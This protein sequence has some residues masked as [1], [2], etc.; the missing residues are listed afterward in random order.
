[1]ALRIILAEDEALVALALADWLEAEG[2]SVHVAADGLKAL[3]AARRLDGLDLLVTDLRM[4]NLGGEGLIRALRADRPAL[5]VV[6][7]TGS[8][9]PGGATELRRH[10]G[11]HGPLAL[12]HKPIDYPGLLVTLRRAVSPADR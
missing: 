9:P 1:M 2:H 6:V 8:A 7:V 11:G 10:G 5:P 12:V 4:P 3:A